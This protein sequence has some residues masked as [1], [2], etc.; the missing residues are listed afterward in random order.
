M[1]RRIRR[2]AARKNEYPVLLKTSGFRSRRIGP[3][4]VEVPTGH[5]GPGISELRAFGSRIP[6]VIAVFES[7]GAYRGWRGVI[8]GNRNRRFSSV[9]ENV[10]DHDLHGVR[11]GIH[12]QCGIGNGNFLFRVRGRIASGDS[13]IHAVNEHRVRSGFGRGKR[14]PGVVRAHQ[15]GGTDDLDGRSDRVL[16]HGKTPLSQSGF[17]VGYANRYEVLPVLEIRRGNDRSEGGVRDGRS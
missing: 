9:V 15:R 2:N 4:D 8:L 5:S 13:R 14:N 10:R 3:I 7:Y 12:R 6:H 1:H 11:T 17:G 16:R